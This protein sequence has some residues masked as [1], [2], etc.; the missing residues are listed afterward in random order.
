MSKLQYHNKIVTPTHNLIEKVAIELAATWYEIG[1]GQGLTSKHKTA[2]AYAA[3]NL[4]KF[5]PKAVEHLLDMLGA[6]SNATPEMKEEIY[7]ALQERLNDPGLCEIMP[8]VDVNKAIELAK[9]M[10]RKKSPIE[11]AIDKA[12]EKPEVKQSILENKPLPASRH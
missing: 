8:N 1:R 5:I 12:F 3:A 6:N 10:E 7:E 4:E 9:Q 2:K 11:I